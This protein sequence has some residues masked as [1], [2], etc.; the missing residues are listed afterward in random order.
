MVLRDR[1][2]DVDRGWAWLVMASAILAE[3]II[4][5]LVYSLGVIQ[6]V[7]LDTFDEGLVKTSWVLSI[8]TSLVNL[9][10]LGSGMVF[11]P[12]V[13]IIGFYFDKYLNVAIALVMTGGGIGMLVGAPLLGFF[14]NVFGWRGM[15]LMLAGISANLFVS[16]MI[17]HPNS[18]ER[19]H[20]GNRADHSDHPGAVTEKPLDDPPSGPE[21]HWKKTIKTSLKVVLSL[22]MLLFCSSIFLWSITVSWVNMYL[23][24]Y[25]M[26]NG[27]TM[28]QSALLFTVM[29][30]CNIVSRL[31]TGFTVA[32]V[33][34]FILYCAS[35]A[36]IAVLTTG[37]PFVSPSLTLSMAFAG[38]MGLFT[39]GP[40]VVLTPMTKDL[41]GLAHLAT[42]FGV[43][44]MV[45]GTGYLIGPP[46]AALLTESSGS[47]LYS[48]VFAGISCACSAVLGFVLIKFKQPRNVAE[49]D[50]YDPEC[51]S[52]RHSRPS[53]VLY[54]SQLS[55]PGVPSPYLEIRPRTVELLVPSAD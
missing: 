34:K 50:I 11:A 41:A 14:E 46:V 2:H 40:Y 20:W 8:T 42:A 45:S 52:P 39:G 47:Y 43:E 13:V 10:G 9:T 54:A 27:A 21:S 7:L 24:S 3:I 16:A 37:F 36:V 1:A 6:I 15:F 29:G 35:F 51:K 18:V 31:L 5:V 33:D 32:F 44:M 12:S 17:I 19:S 53:S 26:F 22:P 28:T 49:L 38:L 55:T 25:V 23:P 48:F 30:V 4:A